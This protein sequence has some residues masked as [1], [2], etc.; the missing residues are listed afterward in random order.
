[1]WRDDR[2]DGDGQAGLHARPSIL[3]GGCH[4]GDPDRIELDVTMDD[5]QVALRVHQ[6]GLEA[7]LP[8]RPGTPMLAIEGRHVA[9]SQPAHGG[10]EMTGR[11]RRKQQVDVVRHQHIG[12][13]RDA[14]FH[15]R[16]TQALA[17]ADEILVIQKRCRAVDAAMR[18]MKR[19]SREFKA[20]STRHGRMHPS[21]GAESVPLALHPGCRELTH[22]GVGSPMIQTNIYSGPYVAHME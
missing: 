15:Q 18:D 5:E 4:H 14:L 3:L 8:Q 9:L 19:H 10:R 7:S 13:K 17:I 2:I 12:V 16:I 1:M 11:R 22:G 21:R 6:A 20:W